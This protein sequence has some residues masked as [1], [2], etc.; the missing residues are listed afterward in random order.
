MENLYRV[1]AFTAGNKGGNLAGVMLDASG[2]DEL[3]MKRIAKVVGYSE[4]AFLVPSTVADYGLKFYTPTEEVDLC[5]H[6]TIATYNILRD[7]GRMELG[8]YTQET[9]AGILRLIVQEKIVYMEQNR[10]LYGDRISREEIS[11]CFANPCEDYLHDQL[12]IQIVSTGM[13]DI[14]LPIKNIEVLHKLEPNKQ[15]IIELS[16]QYNISGI[17]AFTLE[18]RHENGAHGRNFAP[19][20]GIDEESATGTSNGALACYLSKYKDQYCVEHYTFEQGYS[21]GEPSEIKIQLNF[22]GE[23]IHE[24]WVGGS[25]TILPTT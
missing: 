21:M 17:H 8:A 25:A 19:G 13:R 23:N 3:D 16:R 18:T 4:T 11:R 6:A 7:L 2:L 1:Q 9:K 12:P 10:P 14:M 5:G 24:V 22:D 20:C 15:A